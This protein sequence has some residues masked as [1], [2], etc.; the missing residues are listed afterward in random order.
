MEK[1]QKSIRE[2]NKASQVEI[3]GFDEEKPPTQ[4]PFPKPGFKQFFIA[5]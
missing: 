3:P 2:K 5:S 4:I 1:N